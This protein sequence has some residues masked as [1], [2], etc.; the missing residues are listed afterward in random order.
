MRLTNATFQVSLLSFKP[1]FPTVALTTAQDI[2]LKAYLQCLYET[3]IVGSSQARF[4]SGIK[5]FY[6]FLV[7]EDVLPASPAELL[8]A[9]ATARP[10]PEVLSLP[11]IENLI[12][13]ID[14]STP[15]GMRN[16]AILEVLYSCGLRVS[17]LTTLQL[18]NLFLEAG[19]VRVT[20]KGS[21]ERL[22]PI[23]AEAAKH[24]NL[25]LQHTRPNFP[26]KKDEKDTVFLNVRGGQISRIAV[27]QMIKAAAEKAG[28]VANVHPHTFRHSFATHLV[29]A[30]ADLRAVQEMLG[31]SSITTTEIYTHLDVGYL[32]NT[33]EQFHPRF[34]HPN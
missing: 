31:H 19:Y 22:T 10:L 7:L 21:K 16:R 27:F 32:R 8:S 6:K 33:M 11:D 29:E 20:G 23:G 9:P 15:S 34:K 1:A 5:A 4:L 18:S 17:E 14:H 24:V 30:G 25:Y 2:H 13:A 28:I 26:Q 3:G 12:A